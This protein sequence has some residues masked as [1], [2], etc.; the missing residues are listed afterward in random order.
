ML[1][2]LASGT[3]AYLAQR[4][5]AE[6]S[7]VVVPDIWGLRP[8]FHEMCESLA[9]QTGWSVGAFEPFPGGDLPGPDAPDALE[10]RGAALRA[11][12][13]ADLLGDAEATADLLGTNP[14]GLIGF[15]MGGMY[16]LKA[17]GSGRF[18]RVAAFYGMI[19]VPEGWAGDGQGQ[20]LDAIRAGSAQVMAIIG[21]ADAWTPA[22]DVEALEAAGVEVVRYEGADHGFVH[23]PSRPAHRADYA[24]DAWSRVLD[25][26]GA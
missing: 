15:C 5:D 14:C 2:T 7:L 26:L 17:A 11:L 18:D 16:A 22:D 19:R 10:A 9:D 20:P 6:R 21:T 4:A 25:F 12:A 24:A 23:D 3:G 1:G 8:L 13:D